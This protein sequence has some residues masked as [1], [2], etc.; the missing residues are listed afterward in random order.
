MAKYIDAAG[1]PTCHIA[2]VTPI[3]KNVGANRIVH[4][5]SIPHPTAETDLPMQ[6]EKEARVRQVMEALTALTTEVSE[7]TVFEK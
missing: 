1:I 7:S 2:T 6:E 3:S 5:V 4:G